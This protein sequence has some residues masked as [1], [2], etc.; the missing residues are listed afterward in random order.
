MC[1]SYPEKHLQNRCM[2]RFPCC[3]SVHMQAIDALHADG[4][5]RVVPL[6]ADRVRCSFVK[7]SS[8]PREPHHWW[9]TNAHVTCQGFKSSETL[10]CNRIACIP[11]TKI[12]YVKWCNWP[13]F[14]TLAFI[15]IYMYLKIKNMWVCVYIYILY[16]KKPA[17]FCKHKCYFSSRDFV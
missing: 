13:F 11:N 2:L 4:M 7:W 17:Q 15:N 12:I 1:R 3:R 5:Y 9:K 6:T 8:V 16:I 10:V 14:C